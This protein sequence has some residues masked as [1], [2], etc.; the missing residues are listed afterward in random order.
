MLQKVKEIELV[1]WVKLSIIIKIQK[2]LSITYGFCFHIVLSINFKG[3]RLTHIKRRQI[4]VN[5]DPPCTQKEIKNRFCHLMSRLLCQR[6]ASH[7][8]TLAAISEFKI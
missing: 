6:K 8:G 3:N 5:Y 2:T 1:S 7:A 4:F